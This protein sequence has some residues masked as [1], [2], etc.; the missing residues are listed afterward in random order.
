MFEDRGVDGDKFLQ[1]SHPPEP[2]RRPLSSSKRKMRILDPVVEPS[3]RLLPVRYAEVINGGAV[4]PKPIRHEDI[5]AAGQGREVR[6]RMPPLWT[7]S[8]PF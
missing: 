5:R 7:R 3:T 4:R 2:L 6:C 8:A 1:T